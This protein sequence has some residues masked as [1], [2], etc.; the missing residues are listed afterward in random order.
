MRQPTNTGTLARG[1]PQ[2]RLGQGRPFSFGTHDEALARSLIRTLLD[3]EDRS[4]VVRLGL[5]TSSPPFTAMRWL[6]RRAAL[7]RAGPQR[8]P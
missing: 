8:P 6:W 7:G 2:R 5:I 3:P 1:L 4:A